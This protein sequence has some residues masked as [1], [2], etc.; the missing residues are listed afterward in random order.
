[1]QGVAEHAQVTLSIEQEINTK[2]LLKY[3]G[4]VSDEDTQEIQEIIERE[5]EQINPDA[6]K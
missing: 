2:N 6:W 3:C 5:F 1:L 4:T